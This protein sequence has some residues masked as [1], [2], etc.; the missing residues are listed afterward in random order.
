MIVYFVEIAIELFSKYNINHKD[1][2]RSFLSTWT[3]Y[4]IARNKRFY[5]ISVYVSYIHF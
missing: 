5:Y 3:V 1:L 4:F 2:G